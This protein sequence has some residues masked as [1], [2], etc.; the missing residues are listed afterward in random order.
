MD[1]RV[2]GC[3]A[4]GWM[5]GDFGIRDMYAIT[6][7]GWMDGWMA[8]KCGDGR[9][10]CNS[11][12]S[13]HQHTPITCITLQ[14]ST[15]FPACLSK[16]KMRVPSAFF[17]IHCVPACVCTPVVLSFSIPTCHPCLFVFPHTHARRT[18]VCLF[19][20]RTRALNVAINQ[21]PR[22]FRS[23]R[24]MM[25]TTAVCHTALPPFVHLSG[26]DDC[27]LHHKS[28]KQRREGVPVFG[29]FAF[30][31]VVSVVWRSFIWVS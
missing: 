22:D 17:L 1:G 20:T 18:R 24:G 30:V 19:P 13:P 16:R 23:C 8:R 4:A 6:Y 29:S 3:V 10:I 11:H 28:A 7:L 2:A 31:S 27:W 26:R 25:M 14:A 9:S 12:H 15:T 5:D 21:W